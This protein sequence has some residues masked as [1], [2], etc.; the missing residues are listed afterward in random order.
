MSTLQIKFE[1]LVA[2]I[3]EMGFTMANRNLGFKRQEVTT[4]LALLQTLYTTL[5]FNIVQIGFSVS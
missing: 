5:S 2:F 4:L 1:E 3:E